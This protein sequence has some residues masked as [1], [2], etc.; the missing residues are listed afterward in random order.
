MVDVRSATL[1]DAAALGRVH[2]ASWR[3]AYAD[4][5][6]DFVATVEDVERA[7]VWER[8]LG[9]TAEHGEVFVSLVEGKIT[10]LVNIRRSRDEDALDHTG[11]VI[12]LYVDP[13]AWSAGSGRALMAAAVDGLRAMGFGDATLWVIDT[14]ARARRFY[15]IAGWAPDGASMEAV[16]RGVAITEVRYRR[17]LP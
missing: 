17:T 6:T 9:N 3:V 13:V 11:E 10:G 14:N 8:V 5:G 1:G 12:A 2:A 15:E 4:L 16:F 7:A